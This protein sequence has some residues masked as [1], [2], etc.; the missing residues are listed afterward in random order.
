[1]WNEYIIVLDSKYR[2]RGIVSKFTISGIYC[3]KTLYKVI[4]DIEVKN[5]HYV[6]HTNFRNFFP[7][8]QIVGINSNRNYLKDCR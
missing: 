3:L 5:E 6:I 7:I 8:G 1:M 2:K 4:S